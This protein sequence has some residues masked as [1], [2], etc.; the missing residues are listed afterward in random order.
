MMQRAAANSF[1][2]DQHP[3]S[4]EDLSLIGHTL[5]GFYMVKRMKEDKPKMEAVFCNFKSSTSQSKQNQCWLLIIILE[6][7]IL[8]I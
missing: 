3:M 7:K 2:P 6:I 1:P 4:C 5:N 8:F